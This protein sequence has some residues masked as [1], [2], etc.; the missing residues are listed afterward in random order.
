MIADEVKM[1]SYRKNFENYLND[2]KKREPAP[3]G[4]SA[5]CL[6]FCTGLSLIEKAINYSL[7]PTTKNLSDKKKNKKLKTAL[8]KLDKLRKKIYPYIDKDGYL[9]E[10]IIYSR[11]QKRKQFIAASEKIII[12]LG[13]SVQ[14]VFYLAKEVES[15]IKK[16]IIS[17]FRIGLE[18]AKSALFGCI[19]NLEANRAIFGRQNRFVGIF[20]KSLNDY[21]NP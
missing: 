2:L 11:G 9:F 7:V 21:K 20:K 6:I 1:K 19:L 13:E 10:K 15:G 3:G 12:D 8:V 18:F 4:G 5:V 17:D 16:S 14:K